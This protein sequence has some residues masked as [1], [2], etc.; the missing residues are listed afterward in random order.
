MSSQIIGERGFK[1]FEELGFTDYF[2]FGHVMKDPK[3]CKEVLECLL[4]HPVGDLKDVVREREIQCTS[5]GKPIRLDICTED[6]TV[7]F[8]SYVLSILLRRDWDFILL[9]QDV[10]KTEA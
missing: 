2:M 7:L 10:K 6:E 8:Y 4:Q 1:P 5:D 3:I 9:L